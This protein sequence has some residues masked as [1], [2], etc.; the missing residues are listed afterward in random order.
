MNVLFVHNNFPA[1]FK[2]VAA[3]LAGLGVG[4]MAAIGSETSAEAPGVELRRYRSPGA[5]AAA[6]S[7]SRRFE[8]ECRRAEQVM[9]TA[10][11]LKTEGF[12]PE[13]SKKRKK[14]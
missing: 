4:R 2:H 14:N 13:K 7:F 9:F 12:A 11:Q 5:L 3:R 1:Q 6:H 10:L 8:A